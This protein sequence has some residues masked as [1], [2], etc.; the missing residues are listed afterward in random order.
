MCACI[1]F[2]ESHHNVSHLHQ[3]ENVEVFHCLWFPAFSYVDNKKC[4]VYAVYASNH[5]VE[6]VN[7]ARDINKTQRIGVSKAEVNCHAAT[8][9]FCETVWVS[10]RESQN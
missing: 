5:G 7:V 10:A 2:R 4:N 1:R 3:H 8:F 6:K 9:F